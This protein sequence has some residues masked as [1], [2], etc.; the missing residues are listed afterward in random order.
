MKNYTE[1]ELHEMAFVLSKLSLADAL[2]L[3]KILNEEF[4]IKIA[5]DVVEKQVYCGPGDGDW[6]G[7][8]DD[9]NKLYKVYLFNTGP[10]KLQVVKTIKD[11]TGL[12]LRESKEIADASTTAP[13]F[14]KAC[15]KDEAEMIKDR[16]VEAG[17]LVEIRG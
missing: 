4:G 3:M 13:S 10:Y 9:Y 1:T 2:K 7:N 5:D 8:D 12:G 11:L 17:A 16:L 15:R 6:D 14:V